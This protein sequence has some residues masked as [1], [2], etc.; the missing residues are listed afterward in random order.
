MK[1]ITTDGTFEK[2]AFS[3]SPAYVSASVAGL[4]GV[5][6]VDKDYSFAKHFSFV[7]DES[8]ELPCTPVSNEASCLFSC[9]SFPLHIACSQFFKGDSIAI[10]VDDCFR[11][12]MIHVSDEP[13][14]LPRQSLQMSFGGASACSLKASFQMPISPLDL[15]KFSAVEESVIRSYCGVVYTSI[16]TD[17]FFDCSF[18]RRSYLGNNV[19]EY[20]ASLEFDSCGIRIFEDVFLKVKRYLDRIF[21]SSV[22]CADA[23]QFRVREKSEGVV[24]EPDRRVLFLGGFLFE[25]EPFEH[26]AGLV[27]DSSNETAIEFRV[28]LSNSTVSELMQSGFVESLGFHSC[29]YAFLA[30]RIAQD[31]CSSQVIIS[32]N[33]GSDCYLHNIPLEHNIFKPIAVLS[34]YENQKNK[35]CSLQHQLSSG[36]VSEVSQEDTDGRGQRVSR[37]NYSGSVLAEGLGTRQP[38]SATRPFA[39]VHF[40][41][42]YIFPY[43]CSQ[44]SQRNNCGQGYERTSF[45]QEILES[46]LLC[47]NGRNSYG[48]NNSEIYSGTGDGIRSQ[49]TTATRL[50]CP[51]AT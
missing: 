7:L 49:F 1:R 17:Y 46:E 11:D 19:E 35:A 25:L 16:N 6:A 32:D 44:G 30:S 33:F 13:S 31:Y 40:S 37:E 36:V 41:A 27:S 48:K 38:I 43:V 3:V 51:L 47:R 20:P 15:T 18:I 8:Q 29:I 39:F 12:A 50:Q 42:T 5:V 9:P 28:C 21:L 34:F 24:V 23:D 22:D 14:L 26:V 10:L 4:A 45:C 2:P